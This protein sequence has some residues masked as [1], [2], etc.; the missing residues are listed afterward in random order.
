MSRTKKE[1]L[2]QQLCEAYENWA[3]DVC[4]NAGMSP[5]RFSDALY[6][7]KELFSPVGYNRLRAKTRIVYIPEREMP[8]RGG[9]PT[10]A[11]REQ[12]FACVSGGAGLAATPPVPVGV[13]AF[14]AAPWRELCTG[15][16][17]RGGLILAQLDLEAE[18][19][20][21]SSLLFPDGECEKLIRT[22]VQSAVNAMTVGFD[23]GDYDDWDD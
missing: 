13:S 22:A 1:E 10:V 9:A 17:A 15:V 3:T 4:R 21:I 11:Y 20:D 5:A 19:P 14:T 6:P 2:V 16:H 12:F 7:Y 18:K 23:E 8:L